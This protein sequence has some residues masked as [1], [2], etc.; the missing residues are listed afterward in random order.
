MRLEAALDREH[1]IGHA[2]FIGCDEAQF[3]AIFRS[4]IIPLLQE[5]FYNDWETLRAVLGES[6]D[7]G[8]FIKKLAAPAGLKA[9]TKWRWWFDADGAGDLDVLET[10]KRNYGFSPSP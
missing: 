3:N 8:A 9:R 2:L 7:N 10:L 1:R 4:K 5:F 6:G